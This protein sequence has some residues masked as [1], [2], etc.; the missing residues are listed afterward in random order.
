MKNK[1][2]SY[3]GFVVGFISLLAM[4]ILN[5]NET[6]NRILAFIFTINVTVS[7]VMLGHN[8]RMEKNSLYRITINDERNEKIRDKV[9]ATMTPILMLIMGLVAVI[10]FSTN[11]YLPASIL[12]IGILS[13][14]LITIF[15][16][17][18]YEKKY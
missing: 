5:D 8:K 11:N 13:F 4:F 10:C 14:P 3:L 1:K 6:I 12:A 7:T 17:R 2:I 18:Y 9:N 15:V 16:S